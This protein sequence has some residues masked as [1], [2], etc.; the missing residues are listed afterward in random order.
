MV[1]VRKLKGGAKHMYLMEHRREILGYLSTHGEH[2]TLEK[3]CMRVETLDRLI[4]YSNVTRRERVSD[5]D[6][7]MLRIKKYCRRVLIA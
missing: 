4:S 7:A 1:D 3:Y 2:E 5:I 6:K